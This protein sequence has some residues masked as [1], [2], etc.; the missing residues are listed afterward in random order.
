[1]S[2]KTVTF[3]IEEKTKYEFEKIAKAIDVTPSQLLRDFMRA[4][5]GKQSSKVK[6]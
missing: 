1:M 5:V 6:K 2:D 3:R 4:Y